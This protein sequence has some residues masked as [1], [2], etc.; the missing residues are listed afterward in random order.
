MTNTN[1]KLFKYQLYFFSTILL[2]ILTNVTY[3]QYT[4]P[5]YTAGTQ[6]STVR[7]WTPSAP[8]QNPNAL[9]NRPLSDVK[10]ATQYFD[11]F[12][13]LLQTVQKQ[14]SMQTGKVATDL[15]SPMVYDVYGR[16]S[17]NFL[18]YAEPTANDGLFKLNPFQQQG[19]FYA[20][21]NVNSPIVNQGETFFY[22]KNNF[23]ASSLNRVTENYAP[24]NNWAGSETGAKRMIKVTN[25]INTAIDDIK[26]WTVTN[27]V[28]S[29]NFGTYSII[30]NSY[31]GQYP[32]GQLYKTISTNE[33]GKQ[34]I[35]FKDMDGKI[36]LKKIQLASDADDGSGK[37]Y[38]GWLCTQYIYD[39]LGNLRAV[40]SPAM[41]DF[42]NT[43]GWFVVAGWGSSNLWG[44]AL[45]QLCFRYEYDDRQH[46]IMKKLP[47]ADEVYMIYDARDRL[48]MTQDANLRRDNRWMVSL[49]DGLDR[50]VKTGILANTF[51]GNTFG[52]HL[53]A[54]SNSVTY[55]F[56]P[57]TTPSL[58]YWD[59]Y[60]QT[61]YDDYDWLVAEGNP[62]PKNRDTGNDNYFINIPSSKYP[63][64][65]I[66]SFQTKGMVTGTKT[67]VIG[68]AQFLYTG[69]YYDKKGRVLGTTAQTLNQGTVVI[70]NLYNFSGQL[71]C[72]DQTTVNKGQGTAIPSLYDYD[73][74]GRLLTIKKTMWTTFGVFIP[75]RTTLSNQYDALGQLKKKILAPAYNNNVGLETEN[76]EYNIRGWL[77]GIN[78]NYVNDENTS[79]YFGFDLGYDKNGI[80]GNYTPQYNGNIS[81]TIWK[82]K[83]DQQK[84]KYDFAYDPVNRL[85]K[86]DFT[87]Q[88]GSSWDISAGVNFSMK[89]GNGIDPVSAY[90][91][92]G[93]IKATYQMGLKGNASVAVD[94]LSYKYQPN[95]NQLKYVAD[96]VNSEGTKL[97]D[98]QEPA[99]NY[100]D[101]IVSGKADYTYDANGNLSVDNNKGISSVTYNYLN[102]PSLI[103]I[104]GKGNI[105]YTYDAGGRKLRKVTT[106]LGNALNNN[107]TTT[108]D[109][110]DGFVYESKSDN[111]P[112]TED[113]ANRLQ[114]ASQ[115]EGRIRAVYGNTQNANAITN[116]AFD[117]FL[118]DQLGNV[119][120]VLTDEQITNIYPAAT[121]EGEFTATGNK[122]Q[123]NSMVN[124]EKQFY[125]INSDYI[126]N[127]SGPSPFIPSWLPETELNT[128]LYYNNNTVPNTNYPAGCTPLPSS[129]STKLYK[130]NAT[131]NKTGLEFVIKVMAGDKIDIFGRSYFLNAAT[132]NNSNSTPLDLLS[133]M[134][135]MLLTPSSGAAALKGFTPANLA[136]LNTGKIPGGFFTGANG[137]TSLIPKAYINYIFFDEQFKYAGGNVSR[138]GESGKVKDHWNIDPSILQNIT[139]PKNGYIFVYVSNESNLDVFF[140]NLQVIHRPGPIMEETHYYPF[141]LTMAGISSKAVGKLENK[142]KY[143]G[144]EFQSKE[145]SDGSGLELYDYGARNYDPQIGRWHTIDPKADL[146]RRYSPYNYAF[147]NPLRY[148]DPDGRSPED[149]IKYLDTYG[150]SHVAWINQAIN[151]GT[152]ETW[153]A[154]A[155]FDL[156]GYLKNTNVQYIGTTGT[157]YG[158]TIDANGKRTGQTTEFK[159]N[160]DGTVSAG[161]AESAKPTPTI[162]D[163]ANQEP[164][165]NGTKNGDPYGVAGG[166][167]DQL[168]GGAPNGVDGGTGNINP[169]V[170][171][172]ANLVAGVVTTAEG[173]VENTIRDAGKLISAGILSKV[174]AGLSVASTTA[175]LMLGQMSL[176]HAAINYTIAYIGYGNPLLG[177]GLSLAE[178]TFSTIYGQKW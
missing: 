87:Q 138:V 69:I 31:G 121:I 12:S 26:I 170:V 23:E 59:L 178:F 129:G 158:H 135:N 20:N 47:G 113:Y 128:K 91:A 60:T 127:E 103:T 28:N 9:M 177:V 152:A 22:S 49:Y 18:P 104:N 38:I 102:L 101:N 167:P 52:A 154:L 53:M 68:S 100:T 55:P 83:G 15:I 35:E 105:T 109:Y 150:D 118:K 132:V 81:G 98:F 95:S 78:R 82:S 172:Q 171:D 88:N 19:T 143:N 79:N 160:A 110:I 144:K 140:D 96:A 164:I 94:D 176:G 151:Q 5:D 76:Y 58:T 85:M 117:Y 54:A 123:A 77:L 27:G 46:M 131:T 50:P 116:F 6:V 147:D 33:Q 126:V 51:N 66:Q 99:Q 42:L 137:E 14:G 97:G 30:P 32:A 168:N 29:G 119:R 3:S 133:L 37:G 145:F 2:L 141:G 57:I 90:D 71:L 80:L 108:T 43:N 120:M 74:L 13:R 93:N 165:N 174:A 157:E 48:V 44:E 73:D 45:K 173:L 11:G 149:W 40:L 92:N 4:P 16:Q 161:G 134:T 107:T 72:S 70:N 106:E 86:A 115:E 112:K 56:T 25:D 153:A 89:M 61:F 114:F 41:I 155:G 162:H 75:E 64:P 39:D 67:K 10:Q 1:K 63:E 124:Y 148:I 166:V 24:G 111:D 169:A 163:L 122:S 130:L 159:L 156:N 34:V 7:S 21:S 8:E 62:V 136:S 65:Y 142:Y 146:M 125:N 175:S 36:I 84:R 17:Y 139:A